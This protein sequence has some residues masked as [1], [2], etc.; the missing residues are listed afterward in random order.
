[1]NKLFNADV[2]DSFDIY[3]F[4]Q[5][6]TG[7][8]MTINVLEQLERTDVPAGLCN[9]IDAEVFGRVMDLVGAAFY[10]GYRVGRNPDLLILAESPDVAEPEAFDWMPVSGTSDVF[11][12]VTAGTV[13]D[14]WLASRDGDN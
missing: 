14:A 1:M 2:F 7:Q 11:L 9:D 3:P 10:A 8:E 13:A 5:R 12:G 6:L 4:I